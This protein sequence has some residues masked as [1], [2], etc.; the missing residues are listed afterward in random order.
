M[1]M[2]VAAIRPAEPLSQLSLQGRPFLTDPDT[3]K[4]SLLRLSE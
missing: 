1:P 4:I 3:T 2:P